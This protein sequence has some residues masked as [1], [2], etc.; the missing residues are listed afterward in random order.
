ML[1]E[2]HALLAQ[3]L[4]LAMI[5]EGMEVCVPALNPSDILAVAEQ[6]QLDVV[7]LDLDL[8]TAGDG[9]V[10]VEPLSL[11]GARV[12]VVSGETDRVRLA[13]CLESGAHGVV[14]KASPLEDLLDIVRRA[15]AGAAVFRDSDRQDLL[16]QLRSARRA[17]D[18]EL[19][20]FEALSA[21][22]RA[23][24]AAVMEGRAA[25]DIAIADFVSEAT[26]RTQIRGIL[27]KLG[28]SSQ[29]AAVALANQ[30]RWA[31]SVPSQRAQR[32]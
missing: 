26:V 29:L 6:E 7:L 10:L 32:S 11:T 17:R 18:R 8:G 3:S 19:A 28:V 5:D 21:R 24:L 4:R 31:P 1:V 14:S 15:A 25:A 13:A 2:D 30:V 12:V 22:E 16:A 20:P 27:G 9:A 23:V